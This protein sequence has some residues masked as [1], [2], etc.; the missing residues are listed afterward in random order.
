MGRRTSLP[1]LAAICL[2]A[3]LLS[4]CGDGTSGANAQTKAG[5]HA[6]QADVSHA[7]DTPSKAEVDAY[8]AAA[9]RAM[10]SSIGPSIRNLYSSIRIEPVYSSGIKYVY[11]FKNQVEASQGAHNLKTQVTVLRALFHAQVEPELKRLGFAHPSATWTYLNH[12]GSLI[13][14]HTAR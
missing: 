13:W 10:K 4:G 2:A 14:S 7:S 6:S 1:A 8:I 5:T 9:R 11:V 3:V 12:D